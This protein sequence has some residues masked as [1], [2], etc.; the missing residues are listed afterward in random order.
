MSAVYELML[1]QRRVLMFIN[2]QLEF[3]RYIA[4]LAWTSY[5]TATHADGKVISRAAWNSIFEG[6]GGVTA[7]HLCKCHEVWVRQKCKE[8]EI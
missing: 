4:L 3:E 5:R 6:L 8:L 2:W 7:D 1:A